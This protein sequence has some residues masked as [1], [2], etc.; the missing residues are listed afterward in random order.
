MDACTRGQHTRSEGREVR[1][2]TCSGGGRAHLHT[3][4][5]AVLLRFFRGALGNLL[6]EDDLASESDFV[7]QVCA[8]DAED[9][10]PLRTREVPQALAQRRV[11]KA[12]LHHFVC[13]LDLGQHSC[14]LR[15]DILGARDL[16]Q[17]AHLVLG[18]VRL[19]LEGGLTLGEGACLLL[20]RRT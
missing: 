7:D 20:A 5:D 2:A 6:C 13:C 16:L 8:K 19:G 12:R 10:H 17:P 9:V 3:Q 1:R 4:V 18:A 11:W 14:E 15:R